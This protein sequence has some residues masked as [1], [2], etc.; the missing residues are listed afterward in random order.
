MLQGE[1]GGGRKRER[2][3]DGVRQREELKEGEIDLALL[4]RLRDWDSVWIENGEK[5]G[6]S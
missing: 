6:G 1:N 5:D 2:E 3:L 4:V